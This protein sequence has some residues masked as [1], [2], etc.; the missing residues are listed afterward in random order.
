MRPHSP[1][2]RTKCADWPRLTGWSP[3][4]GAGGDSWVG[5]ALRHWPGSWF[6]PEAQPGKPACG[7]DT[8]HRTLGPQPSSAVPAHG[9]KENWVKN[10]IFCSELSSGWLRDHKKPPR[11]N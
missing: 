11:K 4:E 8:A 3:A 9:V 1:A 2:V 6:P 5:G 10:S 7:S